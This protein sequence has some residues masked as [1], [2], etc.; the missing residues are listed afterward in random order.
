MARG[1]KPDTPFRSRAHALHPQ[2]GA[3]ISPA[4]RALRVPCR[5]SRRT[6]NTRKARPHELG[7]LLRRRRSDTPGTVRS[8]S[9]PRA[10]SWPPAKPLANAPSRRS[11]SSPHRRP[12]SPASP[13]TAARI[14]RSAPSCSSARAPSNGTCATC[15]R[16]SASAP[17]ESSARYCPTL[18]GQR[19][20]CREDESQGL[21]RVRWR[22]AGAIVGQPRS[23]PRRP[24]PSTP[25]T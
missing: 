19:S 10:S 5:R 21:P 17:A 24:I 11:T 16:S 20:R 1:S 6:C 23:L 9:A 12:R 2:V 3:E 8:P 14:R 13:A 4:F 15:S 18:N 7:A 25:G 22:V